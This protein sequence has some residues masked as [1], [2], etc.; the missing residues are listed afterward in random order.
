VVH[1][2]HLVFL[3]A[4][5]KVVSKGSEG[6]GNAGSGGAGRKSNILIWDVR[7]GTRI[8]EAVP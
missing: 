6:Y 8:L 4:D 7:S 1:D 5:G 3:T 2:R